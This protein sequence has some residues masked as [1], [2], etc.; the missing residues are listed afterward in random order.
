MEVNIGEPGFKIGGLVA[1]DA[2]DGT[3][4]SRQ[5]KFR[6]GVVEARQIRPGF[7][8]MA[9]FASNGLPVDEVLHAL[10][11]LTVV[12]VRV[13][14]RAGHVL[15]VVLRRRLDLGGRLEWSLMTLLAGHRQMR[16]GQHE[17]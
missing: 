2:G 5:R 6:L 12:R 1:V 3:M 13:T 16:P 8:G 11:E 17:P 7:V 14:G 4:R 10:T 9:S 15:E